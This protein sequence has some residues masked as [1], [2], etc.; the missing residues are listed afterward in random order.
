M[1]KK[2]TPSLI[3]LVLAYINPIKY[4]F[5]VI[6]LLGIVTLIEISRSGISQ[7]RW[8]WIG[9]PIFISMVLSLYLAFIDKQSLEDRKAYDFQMKLARTIGII[10]PFICLIM[11][12]EN[13]LDSEHY[14]VL[15]L[16]C[17]LQIFIFIIYAFAAI[18]YEKEYFSRFNFI[19]LLM[20]TTSLIVGITY[21]S[22]RYVNSKDNHQEISINKNLV[23]RVNF[24]TDSIGLKNINIDSLA[25]LGLLT[26]DQAYEYEI[27]DI[28]NLESN[29]QTRSTTLHR[30]LLL[31]IGYLFLWGICQ[32]KWVNQLY[33]S[34]RIVVVDVEEHDR[35]MK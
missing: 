25:N 16:P 34:I 32:T 18:K 21:S 17:I 10:V 1:G 9:V 4:P 8:Y 23:D 27:I 6:I 30:Y 20:I 12:G 11:A 29:Y 33:S 19:Q 14:T 3:R 7:E 28:E 13:V 24:L 15:Y 26:N 22:I 5:Y 2:K 35:I 31:L